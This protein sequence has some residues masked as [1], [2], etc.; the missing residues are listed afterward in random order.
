MTQGR[1]IID[2]GDSSQGTGTPDKQIDDDGV[3]DGKQDSIAGSAPMIGNV[4]MD[5][6][7]F[8][9][10]IGKQEQTERGQ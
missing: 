10:A 2:S 4:D 7:A 8:K 1:V 5:S 3:D 9:S 6:M